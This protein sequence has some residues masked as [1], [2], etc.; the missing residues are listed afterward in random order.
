MCL[1]HFS[2]IEVVRSQNEEI[3][4]DEE[5]ILRKT[6]EFRGIEKD[7]RSKLSAFVTETFEDDAQIGHGTEGHATVHEMADV[8]LAAV[9]SICKDAGEREREK[10]IVFWTGDDKGFLKKWRIPSS[11][12][13][14]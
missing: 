10:G 12:L 13:D 2:N 11:L 9:L 6:S 4:E 7:V 1:L 5:R 8:N 14:Q 3:D